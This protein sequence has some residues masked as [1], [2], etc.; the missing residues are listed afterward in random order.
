M[1]DFFLR[2]ATKKTWV[3]THSLLF[4]CSMHVLVYNHLVR[5]GLKLTYE[6][7]IQSGHSK[8][9]VFGETSQVV[10]IPECLRMALGEC[11]TRRHY[12]PHLIM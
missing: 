3:L 5:A 2:S 12:W 1:E 10:D 6:Q 4:W 9:G 7:I 8:A 11:S